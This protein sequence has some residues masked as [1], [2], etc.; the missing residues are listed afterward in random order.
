MVDVIRNNDGKI[1][2]LVY[3]VGRPEDIVGPER[4][5]RPPGDPKGQFILSL[6]EAKARIREG[7]LRS[8]VIVMPTKVRLR[9]NQIRLLKMDSGVALSPHE[10]G[11]L[12]AAT[13][14]GITGYK[15][16][17]MRRRRR[18]YF[19]SKPDTT[20]KNNLAQLPSF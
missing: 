1:T 10:A 20:E 17:H 11:E 3:A 4:F 15:L 13:L 5:R 12:Q 8:T 7:H 19:R 18:F 2:D 9:N 14:I 16:I 6:A